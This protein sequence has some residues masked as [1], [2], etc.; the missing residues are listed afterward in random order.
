MNK[1]LLYSLITALI[2]GLILPLMWMVLLV[3]KPVVGKPEIGKSQFEGMS[4]EEISKRIN[5]ISTEISFSERIK[6]AS[7]AAVSDVPGY[8]KASFIVYIIVFLGI[9]FIFKVKGKP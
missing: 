5:E 8:L 4:Q 1:K 6:S 3:G 9:Y 2:V 7:S